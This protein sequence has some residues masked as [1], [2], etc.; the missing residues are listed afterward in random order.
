MQERPRGAPATDVRQVASRMLVAPTS[1]ETSVGSARKTPVTRLGTRGRATG[2]PA[3]TPEPVPV[4]HVGHVTLE[5]QEVEYARGN[6]RPSHHTGHSLR[7]YR[8]SSEQ[9]SCN[10]DRD[11]RWEE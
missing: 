2:G 11:V 8:V 4:P 1:E 10:D 7:V 9:E 3:R 6:V 5:R